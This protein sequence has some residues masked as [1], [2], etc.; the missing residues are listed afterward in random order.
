MD[1]AVNMMDFALNMTDFVL[2]QLNAARM[3]VAEGAAVDLKDLDGRT[4]LHHAAA[5]MQ[6]EVARFLLERGADPRAEDG[7]GRPPYQLV[8]DRGGDLWFA[9]KTTNFASKTIGLNDEFCIQNDG[10]RVALGGPGT[11]YGE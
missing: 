7:H 10:L 9:F 11:T 6:D 2:N 8:P 5:H 3:L 4:P 1:F